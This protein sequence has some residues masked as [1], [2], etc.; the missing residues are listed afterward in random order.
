MDG[1]LGGW[2]ST[3]MDCFGWIS[4]RCVGC[5]LDEWMGL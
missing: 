3:W 2:V 4:D 1:W 5:G